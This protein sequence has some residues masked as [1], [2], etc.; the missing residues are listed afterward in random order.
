MN[1]KQPKTALLCGALYVLLSIFPASAQEEEPQMIPAPDR[2]AGE[3]EGPFDRLVIRGATLIDGTGAPPIGPVDIVIENNRIVEVES[4]GYPGLPI[5]ADARP[6][7][8]SREIDAHGA[9]VMPGIVDMHTH[10]GGASKAPEAEYSYKLWLGHGITTVRGVPSSSFEFSVAEK[11]RSAGN[12]IVAP[13]IFAYQRPGSGEEYEDRQILTPEDARNWV[14]YAARKGAD[15]LKLGA[16]RPEIMEALISEAKAQQLGTTAH[17][18]QMGVAQMNALDA[19]RLGLDTVTHYYGLFE[20]MYEDHDVQP[21]PADMNYNNEQHRFGQVARQWTLIAGPGSERWNAVMNEFLELG[22]TLDPTFGIYSAGRD[23]MRARNADWHEAYTLPTQWDFFTPNRE[24]HGAYWFYW[25]T[26]DEVAWRNFYRLWMQFVNEYKN[27]GGRVTVGSDSGFIYQLYG[28]GT[29]LEMEMLQEAGFHPLEVIR[30][31]TMHGAQE[32]YEP[33][34]QQGIEFGVVRPGLLADLVI[35]DENPL[36]NLKVLYATGAV[37]LNDE[38]GQPERTRGI[39]YTIK[40]GIVY[41]AQRLLADVR[42]MVA[43]QKRESGD[44]ARY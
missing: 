10:T 36:A 18:G 20:A 27:R 40:D 8:G 13:R 32:L 44:L 7:G 2:A 11:E 25:T 42:E 39:R 37:R 5:E 31:A 17:L 28:F 43:A 38:T 29:I 23:V 33:K 14:R 6:E 4:V 9:Y 22:L 35:V 24:S 1:R 12:E 21:W 16:Y 41:D 3:G 26:A 15:G 19:A 34:R 30:S